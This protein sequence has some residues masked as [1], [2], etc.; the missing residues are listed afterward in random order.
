M[1]PD[2][3]SESKSFLNSMVSVAM[4]T[5]NGARFIEEQIKSIINQ[6]VLIDELIVCDDGSTDATIPLVTKI[7]EN[8]PFPVKIH[9]NKKNIGSTR[10]F[11]QCLKMCTGD[12][13]VLTDQDDIWHKDRVKIQLDWLQKHPEK[14]AV[15]S[16]ADVINDDSETQNSTIWERIEFT[17]A[18]REKWLSGK[19]YEILFDGFVV[20]GAT[21]AIRKSAVDFLV[22]FPEHIPLLIHDAWIALILALYDKIG[23]VEDR[24]IQYRIHTTQQVGFGKVAKKITLGN[25]WQRDRQEKLTPIISKASRL[26]AIFEVLERFPDINPKKLVPLK[27]RIEHFQVRASLPSNR[28]LRVKP[29]ISEIVAGQYFYSSKDWWFPAL[30]DLLE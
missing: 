6:S 26:N 19:A 9:V 29:I 13:I 11:E 14:D 24:L 28:L 21:V 23:F 17:P 27:D 25:R 3:I 5:Y 1:I 7:T 16:N 8:A 2:L 4:C 10:N 22:P 12:V 15:F 18:Q 20:T 30:G